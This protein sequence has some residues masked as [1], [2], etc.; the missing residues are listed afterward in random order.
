MMYIEYV[1]VHVLR[2]TL[3]SVL[4]WFK[5][6]SKCGVVSRHFSN[7]LSNEHIHGI[8]AHWNCGITTCK[9]DSSF[10]SQKLIPTVLANKDPRHNRFGTGH[11][12][13]AEMQ[14]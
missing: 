9:K 4:Y 13:V 2:F 6:N 14:I 5:I 10:D 8:Y 11:I 12:F 1:H 7:E 3:L